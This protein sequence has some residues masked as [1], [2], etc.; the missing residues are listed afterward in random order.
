MIK[1]AILP[2]STLFCRTE[3]YNSFIHQFSLSLKGWHWCL[4]PLVFQICYWKHIFKNLK[5]CYILMGFWLLHN[6]TPS[7]ISEI[8]LSW[9]KRFLCS[10]VALKKLKNHQSW[11]QDLPSLCQGLMKYFRICLLLENVSMMCLSAEWIRTNVNIYFQGQGK[12]DKKNFYTHLVISA[13]FVLT[14]SEA[15]LLLLTTWLKYMFVFPLSSLPM[16]NVK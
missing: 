11:K 4:P 13:F 5:Q 3:N 8:T 7:I 1:K 6:K 10:K 12:R 2:A 9:T 16:F 15:P 14:H